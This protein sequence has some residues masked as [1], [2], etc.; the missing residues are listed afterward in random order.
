M[1]SQIFSPTMKADKK[2]NETRSRNM[3]GFF[4]IVLYERARLL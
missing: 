2:T 1:P 4:I 3:S